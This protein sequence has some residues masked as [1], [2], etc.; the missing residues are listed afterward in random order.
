VIQ[1]S[2]TSVWTLILPTKAQSLGDKS[3]LIVGVGGLGCPAA[4]AL[5]RAGVGELVLCDDDVVEESN[6]HRQILFSANDVGK[7]KL[8]VAKTRLLA[9][10]AQNVRLV[11]SRL[12]PE[13]AREMIRSVDVVVEGADNFAT[14]FLASDA[15]FLENRPIVHGAGVQFRGTAWSISPEGAPCYRCLFEDILPPEAAPNCAEAGVLGPVVGVLG[16]LMADL[17]LDVLLG[18]NSRVG[19]LFSFDGKKQALRAVPI[20]ARMACPL[21]S[22][23]PSPSSPRIRAICSTFYENPG[24]Q[25]LGSTL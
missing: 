18:D 13:C 17:T 9:E 20:A 4:L 19:Q 10:G 21:C 14:K 11:R 23:A 5:A 24:Q 1:V 2:V 3:A 16:A 22:A 25:P 12:L 8:D 15:S 6:L 7:E